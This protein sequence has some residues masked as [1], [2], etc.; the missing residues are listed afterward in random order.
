M[1]VKV[2]SKQVCVSVKC[3][4]HP[5]P[6]GPPGPPGPPGVPGPTGSAGLQGPQGTQGV[7]GVPGAT[8]PGGPPGPTGPRGHRGS[9]GHP[10]WK[11]T[12]KGEIEIMWRWHTRNVK[13]EV[14]CRACGGVAMKCSCAY[15][16]FVNS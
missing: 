8:G 4:K 1:E 2:C 7:Q 16:N 14:K 13:V 9:Y 3:P 15:A 11:K 12:R 6:T 10:D 5:G